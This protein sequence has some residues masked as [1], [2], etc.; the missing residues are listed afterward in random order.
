VI[1]DYKSQGSTRG[2][3]N[4]NRQMNCN[5]QGKKEEGDVHPVDDPAA[6]PV[7]E[8]RTPIV[9]SDNSVDG[10]TGSPLGTGHGLP[11]CGLLVGFHRGSI[12]GFRCARGRPPLTLIKK[13]REESVGDGGKA[14]EGEGR[15]HKVGLT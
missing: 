3:S 12:P 4:R 2:N 6:S 5:L 8:L 14:A 13:T 10:G 15:D 9:A 1:G 11:P 7:L